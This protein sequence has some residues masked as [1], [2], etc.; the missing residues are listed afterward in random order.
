[1]TLTQAFE[2]ERQSLLAELGGAKTP[3]E[4]IAASHRALHRVAATL[5]RAE[6][7]EVSRQQKQAVLAVVLAAPGL[8]DA[9]GARGELV[10]PEKGTEKTRRA[11]AAGEALGG[12]LLLVVA[13]FLLFSAKIIP[14]LVL[15]LGGVLLYAGKAL[16]QRRELLARGVPTVD[17]QAL[18]RGLADLCRAADTCLADLQILGREDRLRTG[19]ENEETVLSLMAS[20]LESPDAPS[21]EAKQALRMLGIDVVDFSPKQAAYFDILP[22]LSQGRTLRPALL[23]AGKL[24]RKGV[25][26]RREEDG[27]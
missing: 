24:L 20:L 22:T 3:Q 18:V 26:T 23:R 7:D 19:R 11:G 17:A 10:L 15:A 14:A 9:A 25:A 5:Q 4:A 6:D 13:V 21:E 16:E 8:M 1:M 2:A 12:A 27:R